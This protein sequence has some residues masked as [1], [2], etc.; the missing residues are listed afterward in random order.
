MYFYGFFQPENKLSKN[1]ITLPTISANKC[2]VFIRAEKFKI[3]VVC[4]KR[5][6]V[7]AL[8][9]VKFRDSQLSS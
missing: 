2:L 7:P 5:N 8:F 4:G 6:L 3:S 9:E 1:L